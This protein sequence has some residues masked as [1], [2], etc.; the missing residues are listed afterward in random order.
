V[1]EVFTV[2]EALAVVDL[3]QGETAGI[4]QRLPAHAARLC[5]GCSR[6][7][8]TVNA[9][10]LPKKI[11]LQKMS[12]NDTKNAWIYILLHISRD[13]YCKLD[14]MYV[15]TYWWRRVEF[16]LLCFQFLVPAVVS[17]PS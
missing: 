14:I 5:T 17:A 3:A 15:D 12:K 1:N 9:L 7:I 11:L 2:L 13:A 8:D 6:Y 10:L 16:W 4:L